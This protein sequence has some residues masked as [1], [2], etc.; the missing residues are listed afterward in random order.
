[1]LLL[2]P[3]GFV[4]PP[5]MSAAEQELRAPRLIGT[6]F[7]ANELSARRGILP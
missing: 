4:I 6:V 2:G 7:L 5:E 3:N 1:M